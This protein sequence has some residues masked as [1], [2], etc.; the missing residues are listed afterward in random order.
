MK[1]KGIRDEM[2][3]FDTAFFALFLSEPRLAARP[4]WPVKNSESYVCGKVG[5]AERIFPCPQFGET[6]SQGNPN[7]RARDKLKVLKGR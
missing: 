4:E 3:S 7:L 6:E 1:T 2:S 5:T